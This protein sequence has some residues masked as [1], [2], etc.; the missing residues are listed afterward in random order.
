MVRSFVWLLHVLLAIG[1]PLGVFLYL[2]MS[3]LLGSSLRSIAKA[4]TK[5]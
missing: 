5:S 2:H 4:K 3:A 1:H